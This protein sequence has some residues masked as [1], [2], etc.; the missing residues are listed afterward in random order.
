MSHLESYRWRKMEN[1][2]TML[3]RSLGDAHQRIARVMMP[4]KVAEIRSVGND[5]QVRLDLG[6]SADQDKPVLSPWLRAQPVSAGKL[7]VKVRPTIG[8]RFAMI[9]P[10]GT[11]GEGSWC[12]RGPFDQ[13]HEAP[14]GA[15]DVVLEV[16]NSS[17]TI[18]DG[19][20]LISTGKGS[21]EINGDQLRL[22]GK[23]IALSSEEL[24]HNEKNISS[25]HVHSGVTPGGAD[26]GP[27]A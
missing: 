25:G 23:A 21:F 11:V 5:W 27:P 16:G 18:E 2:L 4:G 24:T 26:T 10:S 20:V 3:E 14:A 12:V 1:R 19:K 15:Q 7:K 17:I 13:D 8:E 9:S 6:L 22:N